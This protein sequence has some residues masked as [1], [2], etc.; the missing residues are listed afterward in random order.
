[1]LTVGPGNLCKSLG[2]DI[3]HY[4][5]ELCGDNIFFCNNPDKGDYDICQAERIGIDFAE[6][7]RSK[8]WRY[9]IKNNEFVSK[10]K[11]IKR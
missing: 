6:E 5:V 8:L 1:M 9:Y 3:S 4:G 10:N 7:Y 11:T 2:I